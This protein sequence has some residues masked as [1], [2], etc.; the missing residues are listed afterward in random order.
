MTSI[1]IVLSIMVSMDL[2]V[3]QLDVKTTFLHGDL[4]EEIYM[5]QQ[6][7]FFKKGKE[8][9]MCWLKKSLS[10]LKQDSRQWYWKL[11]SFMTYEGYY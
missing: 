1:R 10:E 3:G 4:E 11:N 5:K 8:H 2:E 7:G 9:L 6:K